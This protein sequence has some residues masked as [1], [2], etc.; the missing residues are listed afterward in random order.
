LLQLFSWVIGIYA[1]L[2]CLGIDF[3]QLD[4][5]KSKVLLTLGNSNFSGG[6]LAVFFSFNLIF[7]ATSRRFNTK[8]VSLISILLFDL[9]QTGAVQGI[10][11]AAIAIIAA[12]NFTLANNVQRKYLRNIR[13]SQIIV[14]I[15]LVISLLFKSGPLYQIFNRQTLKIRIEYWKIGI[16]MT[17]DHLFLGVGPDGFYDKSSIYMAP[18]TLKDI[19]LTRLD[20]AHNWFI[21]ISSNFG[22][23]A[24]TSLLLTLLLIL[25][26]WFTAILSSR[27]PEPI[28]YASGMA[29]FALLLDA[30]FSIEQ[31]G[32]GIWLYFFAGTLLAMTIKQ[33]EKSTL[34]K[35]RNT[36]HYTVPSLV[37][38][39]ALLSVL[40]I[41]QRVVADGKL[42]ISYQKFLVNEK[43]S[44]NLEG[45]ITDTLT[46]ASE[47]E[48][49]SMV[50]N[51]LGSH[52]AY[53]GIDLISNTY[54]KKNPTSIQAKLI[55]VEV[56]W[57]LNRLCESRNMLQDLIQNSPWDLDVWQKYLSCEGSFQ[58]SNVNSN[59]ALITLPFVQSEFQN[60]LRK[61]A[62]LDFRYFTL[63][64]ANFALLGDRDSALH[65]FQLAQGAR[66][67]N[68]E[69]AIKINKNGSQV[70]LDI[71]IERIFQFV[72]RF[73]S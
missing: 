55:R 64:A 69:E 73:L 21:N 11:I 30:F 36:F 45:I 57:A 14:V 42:R 58:L 5:T 25:K 40:V 66:A 24:S 27:K 39:I 62:Q 43:L 23:I 46:L 19:T 15:Y 6:L 7:I 54:V 26:L 50:L 32:L 49:E 59:L 8:N 53:I 31:P 16:R 72:S 1:L 35:A 44:P 33:I 71:D 41:G 38:V 28:L 70:T 68:L 60:E 67:K 52:G 37:L 17:R 3:V 22:I 4:T 63:E 56:L 29:Y 13:I 47:P 20:A 12:G 51:T 2:Q 10:I 34:K 18:G 65:S 48:Y 9:I 61:S